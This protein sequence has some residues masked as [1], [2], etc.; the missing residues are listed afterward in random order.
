MDYGS[1][2]KKQHGN[3]SKQSKSYTKQSAFKGSDREVRGAILRALTADNHTKTK[4]L[5]VLS[6][7]ETRILQQLSRLE[8][9]ALIARRQNVFSL[10]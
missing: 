7:D 1:H 3:L 5:Q 6:Y 4:L 10:P 2:L 9:E 8:K